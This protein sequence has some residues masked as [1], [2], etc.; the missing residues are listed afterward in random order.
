VNQR[1]GTFRD[2][3]VLLGSAYD[4]RGLAQGSMGTAAVDLN[5]DQRLDVLLTNLTGE[6]VALYLA[7][8]RGNFTESATSLGLRQMTQRGTGF[9]LAA[10]D[11]DHNGELDLI[12]ANGAIRRA[13]S[14]ATS[15]NYWSAYR[16]PL[17]LLM[18]DGSLRF[19]EPTQT[20]SS[21]RQAM[22]VSRGLAVGDLDNDGD[23][24]VLVTHIGEASEIYWNTATKLGRSLV[25]RLIDPQAGGRD[26]YGAIVT[27]TAGGKSW[28]QLLQ[29]GTS[30][31]S[32]HDPRLHFGLGAVDSI[33][34]IRVLWPDGRRERFVSVKLNPHLTLRKGEGVDD[35][36]ASQ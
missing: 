29:P 3:A 12:S 14:V 2:E 23:F 33:E 19:H 4:I 16:Q 6:G 34:S 7:D 28:T 10:V 13:P 25:L 15:G 17:Q 24:D 26:A 5:H 11:L 9:G 31:L 27:V 30:Y 1:D 36:A 35:A 22:H 20:P 18:G 21:F 32:S 8:E